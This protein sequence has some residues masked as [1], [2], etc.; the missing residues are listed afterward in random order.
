MAETMSCSGDEYTD[1][2]ED[3]EELD[4]RV[5]DELERLNVAANSVNHLEAELDEARAVFRQTLAAATYHLDDQTKKV[6]LKNIN[7]ARPFY[8]LLRV[9]RK[10]H[11]ELQ[12]ASRQYE[13]ANSRHVYA[14]QRV[15]DAEYKV[16]SSGE[17]RDFDAAMQEM[18]NQATIEVNEAENQKKD[19]WLTHQK[20]YKAYQDVEKQAKEMQSKLKRSIEKSRPYFVQKVG[21]DRHL[22]QL[23][24]RVD[25]I[26]KGLTEAKLIYSKCLKSLEVIS[27]D[28]HQ[29]RKHKKSPTSIPNLQ[30][31]GDGVGAD[32][33]DEV[34]LDQSQLD[35]DLD[36]ESS[37]KEVDGILPNNL[38]ESPTSSGEKAE[39]CRPLSG[40]EAS[41]Q[42]EN[43]A[44]E[45]A[46][47]DTL[48]S[49]CVSGAESPRSPDSLVSSAS[50]DLKREVYGCEQEE[51]QSR[52]RNSERTQTRELKLISEGA[53]FREEDAS[54][55]KSDLMAGKGASSP[56]QSPEANTEDGEPRETFKA[57]KS[58]V[59]RASEAV[60]FEISA[61]K[62][63][64]QNQEDTTNRD[65][66]TR[67]AVDSNVIVETEGAQTS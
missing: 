55:V 16:F 51:G 29:K 5:H 14:R 31:R 62:E 63:N 1:D 59:E 20:M 45:S 54:L 39:T 56:N 46:S 4:P 11:F 35:L 44:L 64:S 24:Q 42:M 19:S 43:M 3:G 21:F 30:E 40:D 8:D 2:D 17:K 7:K 53:T 38:P 49:R 23:R 10:A 52:E 37:L 66:H 28:I 50:G 22:W 34:S 18:L 57:L 47:L 48:D 25:S 67:E 61:R 32:S 60:E 27:D 9:M 13:K 58:D 65:G 15:H 33:E 41:T 12:K 6:G 26:Q 36:C